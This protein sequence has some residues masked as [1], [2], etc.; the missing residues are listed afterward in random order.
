MYEGSKGVVKTLWIFYLKYAK[1]T[2]QWG[3][4]LKYFH[5]FEG[6]REN[7]YHHGTFQ[8]T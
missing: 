6:G 5:M 4:G 8:P 1:R 2:M 3:E 7:V